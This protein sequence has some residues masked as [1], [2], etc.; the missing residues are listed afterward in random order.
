MDAKPGTFKSF[1]QIFYRLL[2]GLWLL[3]ASAATP[4]DALS[5]D[6]RQRFQQHTTQRLNTYSVR[7]QSASLVKRFYAQRE[8]QPAWLQYPPH[9]ALSL[10]DQLMQAISRAQTVGLSR[11]DY[12]YGY[13]AKARFLL[14]SRDDL[15]VDEIGDIELL[16][17][18][19][20]LHYG[21][22]LLHG[23]VAPKRIHRRWPFEQ[24]QHQL[25]DALTT[26]LAT[27]DIA[28]MLQHLEPQHTVYQGLKEA[29]TR[30]HQIH[31]QGGWP[32]LPRSK[33]LKLGMTHPHVAILRERLSRSGDLTPSPTDSANNTTFD[34]PLH[35][36]VIGFQN[37]HGLKPDGVVG[38]STRTALN[39]PITTR[40]QQIE[41]NLERWR[42]VP[43]DLGER[44]IMVNI[45]GF[46][47]SLID[48]H[49]PVLSSA[50]IVG[51]QDRPTPIL[52]SRIDRLVF[53]PFWHV[54]NNIAVKDKL[55]LLR[56][57]PSRLH[58]QGIRVFNRQGRAI[59]PR[60]INWHNVSRRHFPY[61]LRQNPGPRNALGR[62]K[63]LFPNRYHV[64]LHDTSSPHLFG[65]S[66]RTFSSG[67][68]RIAKP[69]EL[70]QYLLRDLPRWDAQSIHS[71]AHSGRER[72]VPLNQD[73]PIHVLYWTVWQDGGGRIQFRDDIYKHDRRLQKQLFAKYHRKST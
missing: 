45:A 34:D 26:A 31:Q 67:C 50:V 15:S 28:T 16:L 43:D 60:R 7:L 29:L 54:P 52:S 25:S 41:L 23:R 20:F 21:S 10:M 55:P 73:I 62:V 33:S 11:D 66:K 59:D 71:A 36:A 22:H 24:R 64:Y 37:R 38:P 32:T 68:V 14:A 35:Q 61:R 30:Y 19:A 17:T 8:Y 3:P 13:I 4:A 2:I 51:R 40:L 70:A 1:Y 65:R 5:D 44:Y 49:I 57:N 48:N 9:T 72:G 56:K 27:Q 39:I 6:L 63:F 58:R 69:M 12:H 46:E 42:W 47:M 18:D 53:S